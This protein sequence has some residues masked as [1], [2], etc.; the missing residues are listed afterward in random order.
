VLARAYL[1]FTEVVIGDFDAESCCYMVVP[2]GFLD[3][4]V[5]GAE[6][7]ALS[8]LGCTF[9]ALNRG[10]VAMVSTHALL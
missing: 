8:R 7:A 2:S 9:A 5:S 10:R 6:P 1:H 3:V 4:D